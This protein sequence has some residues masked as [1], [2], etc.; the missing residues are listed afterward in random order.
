MNGD[1]ADA[2]ESD[3]DSDENEGQ[4]NDEND[5]DNHADRELRDI[6]DELLGDSLNDSMEITQETE[7]LLGPSD[8]GPFAASTLSNT[9]D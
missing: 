1:E 3:G 4:V 2:D 5:E 9:C 7:E 8:V 6:E